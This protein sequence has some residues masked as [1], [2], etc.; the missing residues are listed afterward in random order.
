MLPRVFFRVEMPQEVIGGFVVSP[1]ETKAY[2][3]R[4]EA[5]VLETVQDVD[6]VAFNT[7]GLGW[8]RPTPSTYAIWQQWW[9]RWQAW[10]RE[11]SWFDRTWGATYDEIERWHTE[12]MTWRS[13]LESEGVR[14]T[15]DIA[16]PDPIDPGSL[17]ARPAGALFEGLGN[18]LGLALG[19]GLGLA[20]LFGSKAVR[21]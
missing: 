10:W 20:L 7:D 5:L 14:F 2:G 18:T 19:V 9:P 17:F 6:R 13:V 11:V 16:P 8:G 3:E 4:V 1:A 15:R 12:L 21:Q